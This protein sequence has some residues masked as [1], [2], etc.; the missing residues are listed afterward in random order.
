MSFRTENF[1]PPASPLKEQSL[2]LESKEH[3]WPTHFQPL[4]RHTSNH[5]AN[6]P[7]EMKNASVRHPLSMEPLT[8]TLSSRAYLNF[9][10][11]SSQ[12]CHLC[13]SPQREPH[14]VVRSRNSRQEIRGSRGICSSADLCWKRGILYSNKIVISTGPGF[15]A[16]PRWTMPRVLLSLRKAA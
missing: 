9:L 1:V 16:T 7:A 11:H 8:P 10:L 2:S 12:R 14:A 6:S 5:A 4:V 15:P 3:F 13:G